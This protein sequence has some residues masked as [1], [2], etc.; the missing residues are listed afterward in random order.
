[1]DNDRLES[2]F[3]AICLIKHDCE[4]KLKDENLS[5]RDREK[6]Q[7]AATKAEDFIQ[8]LLSIT[9]NLNL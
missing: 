9:Y 7:M 1:M 3:G 8:S 6:Y 5:N 2:T 4:E